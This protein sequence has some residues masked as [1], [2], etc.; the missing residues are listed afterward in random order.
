M[1]NGNNRTVKLNMFY[2]ETIET[3]EDFINFVSKL[4]NNLKTEPD[5]W[6]NKDICTYLE[7]MQYWVE[8]MEQYYINTG[9]AIPDNINWKVFSDILMAAKVYE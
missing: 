8:G 6:E 3:K 7:A 5:G 9:Q 1:S 4:K 2:D